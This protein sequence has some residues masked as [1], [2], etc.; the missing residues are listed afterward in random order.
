MIR[1]TVI[2]LIIFTFNACGQKRDS[3]PSWIQLFN[4]KD[5]KDWK[6]K[7]T[8]YP[9]GENFGNTF[10]V[11]DG[12]MTVGY[13]KYDS[14]N[15]RFGHIF[16][17]QKFSYYLLAMEYRFVGDQVSGGPN[18]AIRNSGAMIHGQSPESM[19]VK[20]DFPISIEVQLLG[21]NGTD[22]RHRPI[23]ARLAQTW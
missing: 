16:Y 5:L 22:E 7:I 19:G 3:T 15:D 17:K 23:S 13:E 21:G 20:Q 11:K 18:W 14:F 1:L 2:L 12:K 6:V 9:L 10:R 4:G 8:G